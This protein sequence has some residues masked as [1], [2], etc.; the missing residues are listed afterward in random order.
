VSRQSPRVL[1]ADDHDGILAALERLLAPSCDVVGRARDGVA[2]VD[3]A[4]RLRPDVIVLDLN[5][6]AMHGLD[7]CRRIRA[8]APETAIVLLT[9]VD[10]PAVREKALEAGASA[11]VRKDRVAVALVPAIRSAFRGDGRSDPSAGAR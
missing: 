11:F 6:P 1:L 3:A 2:V 4:I 9:A 8:E 7:A 5:M 10:D